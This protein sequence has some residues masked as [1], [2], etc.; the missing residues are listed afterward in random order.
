MVKG[1]RFSKLTWFILGLTL[2][3]GVHAHTL[4]FFVRQPHVTPATHAV[5]SIQLFGADDSGSCGW[6]RAAT[7]SAL[8]DHVE[9][10]PPDG[11]T[12]LGL[13]T[14]GTV[15]RLIFGS[16]VNE[17]TKPLM[18]ATL[19]ALPVPS[20]GFTHPDEAVKAF[21][22]QLAT[23]FSSDRS[24]Q[25]AWR[26]GEVGVRAVLLWDGKATLDP[27][28]HATPADFKREIDTF[29][30]AYATPITSVVMT[31]RRPMQQVQPRT[32]VRHVHELRIAAAG[33]ARNLAELP[34]TRHPVATVAPVVQPTLPVWLTA[35]DALVLA[36]AVAWAGIH[37]TRRIGA[38]RGRDRQGA[39]E[40][41]TGE[42][43][44]RSGPETGS[45]E[46]NEGLH[47]RFGKA[48]D[49][50]PRLPAGF[51]VQLA[52]RGVAQVKAESGAL[53]VNGRRLR[54]GEATEIGTLCQV[55]VGGAEEQHTVDL[56]RIGRRSHRTVHH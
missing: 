12:Y 16:I 25:A 32:S 23:L 52:R 5:T 38:R 11:S 7:V 10:T 20:Q 27:G 2:L 21:E 48:G 1:V 9:R 43:T 51:V 13:F 55:R 28:S 50:L 36:A 19:K 18:L 40:R 6:C 47:T 33:L 22:R 35:L 42:W 26:D 44:Y 8:T 3:G 46:L 56:R 41:F 29:W 37:I 15:S 14:F 34:D 17:Q 49:R 39:L 4:Q 53:S 54:E 30:H 24:L 45:F 31:A